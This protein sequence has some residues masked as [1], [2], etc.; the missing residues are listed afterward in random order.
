MIPMADGIFYLVD[1]I[2]MYLNLANN[3]SSWCIF[4]M[5]LLPKKKILLYKIGLY[6]IG[7]QTKLTSTTMTSSEVEE[8][9][10]KKDIIY[11]FYIVLRDLPFS[12]ASKFSIIWVLLRDVSFSDSRSQ[13]VKT[14]VTR[15]L[16]WKIKVSLPEGKWQNFWQK[17]FIQYQIVHKLCSIPDQL[18]PFSRL[19]NF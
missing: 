4:I 18:G 11:R 8:E 6:K 19:I 12:R 14:K 3:R 15:E 1:G 2:L 10:S 7:K 16:S 5:L 17:Q 13:H 9:K